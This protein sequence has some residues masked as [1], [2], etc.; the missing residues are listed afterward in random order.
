MP[1][2]LLILAAVGAAAGAGGVAADA[3]TVRPPGQAVA[4]PAAVLHPDALPVE[5]PFPIRRLRVTDQQL[6]EAQKQ[7]EAGPVVRLPRGEFDARVRSAGRFAAEAKLVPRI[8]DARY[9]AALVDGDLVGSAELEIVHSGTAPRFFP[10]EPCRLALGPATWEDGREAVVA[11]PPGGSGPAVWL[12]RPGRHTLKLGWSAA[13]IAEPGER[14]FEFRVPTSP[15]AV[16]TLDLPAGQ[17]PTVPAAEVLLT[18]PFPAGGN[19]PRAEWRVRFGGRS[20][21]DV[22]VRPA[23]HSGVP[24]AATLAARYD[25]APGQ[26]SCSFEYD[27][28]PATGTVGEWQFTVDPGLRIADVVM[29]NRAGWAVDPTSDPNA[30]RRLRVTLRQPGAGG[31]AVV[32]AVAPYPDPRRPADA[33]L[34]TVRPVGAVLDD[35]TVEIRVQGGLGVTNWNPGD[36]RLVDSQTLS[37][38]T[39]SLSLTGTLLPPGTDR[40]FRKPPVLTTTAVENDFTTTEELAWRFDV[41]RSSVALRVGVKVRR[42]PL[43]AFAL[44]LPQEFSLSRVDSLPDDLVSHSQFS[45][46]KVSVEFSRPLTT[47]QAAELLFE[48]RGPDLAAGRNRLPFPVFSPVGSR[49]RSGLVAV[50]PGSV[51]ALHAWAGTG[52][53]RVGWLD[54]SSPRAPG[55]AAAAFRYAGGD[56]EGGVTLRPAKPEFVVT[57]VAPTDQPDGEAFTIDVQT[58]ALPLVLAASPSGGP[59]RRW[60][61]LSGGNAVATAVRIPLGPLLAP[62]SRGVAPWSADLW[63]IA[64]ARPAAGPLTLGTAPVPARGQSEPPARLS[65]LGAS[66]FS[67]EVRPPVKS[68]RVAAAPW[69]FRDLYLLTVVRSTADVVGVF[70]GSTTSVGGAKLPVA[71]P[72]GAELVSATVDGKWAT[73]GSVQVTADGVLELAVP[74]RSSVRFEV[75]YRLPVDPRSPAALVCSPEPRLPVPADVARWWAFDSTV[76]AGWPVLPWDRS[77]ASE[78]PALLGDLPLGATGVFVSRATFSEVR[79][80]PAGTASAAGGGAAAL[81]LALGWAAGRRRH[82]FCGLLLL[83]CLLALAAAA[84]FGPPWW[85]RAAFA[86][87]VV[88]LAVA[89]GVV[90]VRGHRK[91]AVAVAAVIAGLFA[92]ETRTAAQQPPS[93]TVILLPPDREGRE[94]VVAPKALLDRL[95]ATRPAAPGVVLTAAEYTATAEE[96]SARVVAK[97]IAQVLPEADPVASLTLPDARLER[98]TVN[99]ANAFPATPRPGVYAVPLPGPGRFEIEVRFTVAIAGAGSEREVRFGIPEVPATRLVADLP[100]GARQAQAVGRIGRQLVTPGG[101]VRL[102][103]DLGP[104]KQFHARWR[105]GAGGAATIKVREGCV[106]DVTEDGAELTACYVVRVEQGTVTSV[107]FEIPAELEPQAL[108]VRSLDPGGA[109]ALRDW[110]LAPEQGGFRP[111]KLDLQEATAGRVLVVLSL[112]PQKAVTRQPLLRFPKVVFPG[113]VAP[114]PDAAYGLRVK[115]VAIEE[116]G[117]AGVIDFSPDALTKEFAGV[118]ELRLDPNAP[119]RVFRPTVR[120][121]AELR[122]TLRVLADPPGLTL[123]TV[124]HLGPRRAVATGTVTWAGKDPQPLIELG[125]EGVTV[126]EVRGS[127]VAG[128]AQPDGRL[129]VWLQRAAK[130]GEVSWTGTVSSPSFP[131]EAKTPRVTAG[132]RLASD[133]VRV[134][135]ADGY[136]LAVERDRGWTHGPA[137]GDQLSYRTSTASFPPIRVAL[138][139]SRGTLAPADLGWLAPSARA[140]VAAETRPPVGAKPEAGPTAPNISPAPQSA[141][142]SAARWLLPLSLAVGW[143]SAFGLLLLMAACFQRSTW[144]EQLGLVA[145]FLGIA[146]GVGWWVG[147]PVWCAARVVWLVEAVARGLRTR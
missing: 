125:L 43:F 130:D 114:P 85:Q 98:V 97:F 59:E 124:W 8:A 64:L 87:L 31:K 101:R 32:T 141:G 62:A 90:V 1:R 11:I 61:V 71:L 29:N 133:S 55:G 143:A 136:G 69:G 21:L 44:R 65:I 93:A 132:G 34:P 41:H 3:P 145:G 47:G 36:Y 80:A 26:L 4:G 138:D 2:W 113:G 68:E 92:V 14:R 96:S 131:F 129:Q 46:G 5:D 15:T 76:L 123:D 94:T 74:A 102:E 126:T 91:Y 140:G 89:G 116:L 86:P 17:V 10:L 57:S 58:G 137:A 106:W 9:R 79:V 107:R 109:A 37:D 81:L 18:G 78:L 117:R 121:G 119:V 51:W 7:L 6:S 45:N 75:R 88:G 40:Q 139:P 20:R 66:A 73:P 84:H 72:P 147:V 63:L 112:A 35:E 13:G 12:D 128:W 100:G 39:R 110:S 19:P 56:P 33:P 122:P 144:P 24:A 134:R 127:D 115:G 54:P 83:T 77:S 38:Q 67:T 135:P 104:V 30:P 103:A 108:A 22:A 27:L 146:V 111:L 48:F 60:S 50:F 49:E 53:S 82:P 42:G 25:V 23:G 70:G 16:L 95:A 105:D 52:T 99:G 142:E 28:R 120:G 118:V